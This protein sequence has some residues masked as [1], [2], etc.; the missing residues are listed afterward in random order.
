[1]PLLPTIVAH[2]WVWTLSTS[3]GEISQKTLLATFQTLGWAAC[4]KPTDGKI[5]WN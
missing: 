4:D 2:A 3:S 5:I 1:M